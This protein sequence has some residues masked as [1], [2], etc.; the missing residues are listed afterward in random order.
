MRLAY[1]LLR[2]LGVVKDN[3]A[4]LEPGA[5]SSANG[6]LRTTCVNFGHLQQHL[7]VQSAS[8][9]ARRV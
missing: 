2:E 7:T 4:V 9:S 5:I 3:S 6:I 8:N 1:R